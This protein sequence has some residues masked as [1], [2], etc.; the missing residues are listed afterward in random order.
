MR[1]CICVC[2]GDEGRV[3]GDVTGGEGK[4]WLSE[5]VNTFQGV[6]DECVRP[7]CVFK[8]LCSSHW[9]EARVC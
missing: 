7:W 9:R 2:G 1:Y 4:V 5:G 6:R 3:G 8:P